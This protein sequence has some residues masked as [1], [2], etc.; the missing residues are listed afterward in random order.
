[1]T[2]TQENPAEN[3]IPRR[4]IWDPEV[5]KEVCGLIIDGKSIRAVGKIPGMPEPSHIYR[6]MAK[7]M[8][9]REAI[10]RA[11]E[12]GA[13]AMA[14]EILEIADN[15][16]EKDINKAKIQISARQ[17]HTSKMAPK[18]YGEKQTVDNNVSVSV[19]KTDSI[20]IEGMTFDELESLEKALRKSGLLEP[21]KEEPSE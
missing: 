15:A 9:I 21:P 3:N 8:D 14:D 10:T 1:M 6:A 19:T 20:N 12:A 2:D 5:L 11:R 7:N 13:H 17:W 18:V 16:T 4:S